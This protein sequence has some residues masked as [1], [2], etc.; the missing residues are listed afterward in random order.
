MSK[1]PDR[2]PYPIII[3]A[4][5][6]IVDILRNVKSIYARFRTSIVIPKVE[7]GE[8]RNQYLLVPPW[9]SLFSCSL[10][11]ERLN[12]YRC[13]THNYSQYLIR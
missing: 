2:S 10:K 7:A 5:F 8:G 12:D 4:K 13:R 9:I 3:G 1:S 6:F 11:K